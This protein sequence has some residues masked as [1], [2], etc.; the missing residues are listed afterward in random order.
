MCRIGGESVKKSQM[1][2]EKAADVGARA[3]PQ[4]WIEDGSRAWVHDG[5]ATR[6]YS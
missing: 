1:A 4:F 6:S 5:I 3:A 2:E